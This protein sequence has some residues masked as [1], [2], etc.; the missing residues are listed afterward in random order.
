GDE[1]VAED[2]A[3]RRLVSGSA[4]VADALAAQSTNLGGAVSSTAAM[5]RQLAS[6]RSAIADTLVR[7][8]SVLTQ[9]TRVLRHVDTTL[10]AL[11]PALTSLQPV[12]GRLARL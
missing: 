9:G 1:V 2:A 4:Q 8:P 5:L 3:L 6:Q 11:D 10:S 12:A 7:A